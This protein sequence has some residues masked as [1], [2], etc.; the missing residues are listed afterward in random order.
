MP[1]SSPKQYLPKKARPP[2]RKAIRS[3]RAALRRLTTWTPDLVPF[4][5]LFGNVEKR[6]YTSPR[7]IP[8]PRA[9]SLPVAEAEHLA[10]L[11]SSTYTIPEDFAA[12]LHDVLY[13]P[14][15]NI[16]MTQD[17]RALAE[18]MLPWKSLEPYSRFER[19]EVRRLSGHC[20][21]LHPYR[22]AYYH[23]LVDHLPRVMAL[24]KAPYPELDEIKLLC[25]EPMQIERFLISKL[26]PDNVRLV[27]PDPQV[28]YRIEHLIFTPLKTRKYA[29]YLPPEYVD[30]FREKV[31][32]KRP[33][34]RN[35]RILISRENSWKRRI[36]NREELMNALEQRGFIK[37]LPEE[38]SPE[39][40][41]EMFYDAEVVM[42]THGSGLTNI[43]FS[44]NL[45]VVE[46][47]P[48]Q[49][50]EPHWY[51]MCASLGHRY[52]YLCGTGEDRDASVAV[53]V[54]AVLDLLD[55]LDVR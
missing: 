40:E 30:A 18:S 49:Y 4:D 7:T 11:Q 5:Q 9:A 29:G 35:R 23:A 13:C 45:K 24:N 46:L 12:D 15:N 20:A 33:S 32:P 27:Q 6:H 14:R 47:F 43:L 31:L 41:V 53:D 2:A 44:K 28:L 25:K 10:H 54:P 1:L 42:G 38:L 26:A 36:T 17:R 50:A 37:V 52:T 48:M 16:V 3:V 8:T 19:R 39:E 21:I 22:Q 51:F 34:R 55:Q